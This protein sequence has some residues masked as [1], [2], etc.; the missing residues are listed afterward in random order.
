MSETLKKRLLSFLWRLG[1]YVVVSAIG[2]TV[3]S[4]SE[5]GVPA[6][7]IAVVALIAGEVTKYLNTKYQLG[8]KVLGKKSKK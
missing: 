2:F 3:N 5:F 1:A 6:E 8:A 7:V 4:L